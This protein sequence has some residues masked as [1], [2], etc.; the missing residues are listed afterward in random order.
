VS[1]RRGWI[2]FGLGAAAFLWTV[3]LVA[4]AF[5][6]PA[7]SGESC[8]AAPGASPSCGP[9]PS[10]TLFGVNGWWIVE[11]L[12]GVALVAGVAL[13]ALHVRCSRESAVASWVA[14]CCIVALA[15]FAVITGLSIGLFVL[16]V[17]V[18]LIASRRLTPL[19]RARP[20]P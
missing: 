10:Q 2:A 16:P 6:V 11:L 14:T 7:Y 15:F 17:V 18:L 9:A 4:A 5:T 8:H 20:A 12:L 19:A 1:S 13:W 3:A